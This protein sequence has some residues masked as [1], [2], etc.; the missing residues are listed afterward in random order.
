[1]NGYGHIAR[2]IAPSMVK[3]IEFG[4]ELFF[5]TLFLVG[6]SFL[7]FRKDMTYTKRG[8]YRKLQYIIKDHNIQH[9]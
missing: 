8:K 5:P 1:M 3:N 4:R 2:E 6:Y 7:L 9:A